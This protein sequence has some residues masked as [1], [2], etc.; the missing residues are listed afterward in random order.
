LFK[1]RFRWAF[2]TL[3][4]LWKHRGAIGRYGWFGRLALPSMWLFQILFQVVSPL[5]DLQV[6]WTLIRVAEAYLTRGLLTRDWQPLPQ[7][8][9][10]LWDVAALYTF[11]VTLELLAAIVAFRLEREKPRLLVWVFW[12]RFV[13]R[14]LMYAVVLRALRRAVQGVATG[15]GKLERKGTATVQPAA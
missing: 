4:C 15:W 13:Y 5:I 8:V 9:G 11:F 3:Q 7:A 1:Q 12:Q 14:Q 2:G 6:A 10:A